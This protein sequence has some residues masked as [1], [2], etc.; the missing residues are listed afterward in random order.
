MAFG[1]YTLYL[2]QGIFLYNTKKYFFLI[3][4]QALYHL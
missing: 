2:L 1:E 3:C 4:K